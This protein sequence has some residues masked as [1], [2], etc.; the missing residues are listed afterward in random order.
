MIRIIHFREKCI[1]CNA[2][3]ELAPGRWRMSKKDG[4]SVLLEGEDVN[5]IVTAIA[6]DNEYKAN[7]SASRTCPTNVIKVEKI[8][9]KS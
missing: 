5:G 1:G 9:R 7:L 4:K 3:V 8:V 6:D 2:C